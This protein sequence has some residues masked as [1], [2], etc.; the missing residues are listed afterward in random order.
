MADV[1]SVYAFGLDQVKDAGLLVLKVL[2]V[3]GGAG[4][5]ALATGWVVRGL[6]R[7]LLHRPASPGFLWVR[8]LGAAAGGLAAW[9][10]VSGPGG[11]GWRGGGSGGGLGSG[12]NGAAVSTHL[13]GKS[14]TTPEEKGPRELPR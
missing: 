1:T 8:W 9:V 10:W 7:L 3:I 6:S 4:L 12:G 2:A 13:E 11:S 14:G 5:G